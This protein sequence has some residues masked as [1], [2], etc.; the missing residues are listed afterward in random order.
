MNAP[1]NSPA[2]YSGTSLHSV[3][4]A[5][6]NPSVTAGLRCAPLNWPT[7]NDADHDR[8]APAERDHDPARVLPFGQVEQHTGHHAV[9]QQDQE[10]RPDHF[11]SE[12]AQEPLLSSPS[13]C[14]A[15]NGEAH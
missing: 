8:H 14:P 4:P 10:R 3:L 2:K 13:S 9:A 11:R 1:T 6:A 5:I 7:A 12:D 15:P